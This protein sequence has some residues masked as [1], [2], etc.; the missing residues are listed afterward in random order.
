[1][2]IIAEQRYVRMSPRKVRE[3]G[4]AIRGMEDPVKLIEYLGFVGKRAAGPIIKT[5]KQAIAN[6]KNNMKVSE[7]NLKIAEIIVNEG[8]RYKRFRAGS[9]GMAKPI[10]KRTSHIRVVLETKNELKGG[11]IPSTKQQITN[12]S[13]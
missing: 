5:L 11:K 1:M 13:E 7:D 6:A 2:L 12:K 3:V 10:V 8:P 9:R 4:R